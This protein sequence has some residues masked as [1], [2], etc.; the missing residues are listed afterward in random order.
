VPNLFGLH[1]A[2]DPYCE[3]RTTER[4][5]VCGGDGGSAVC[6]GYGDFL[7]WL[8]IATAYRDAAYAAE[9]AADDDYGTMRVRPA[10]PLA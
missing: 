2:Q 5:V 1:I 8:T 4:D 9:V 3:E 10:I 7:A 6:G